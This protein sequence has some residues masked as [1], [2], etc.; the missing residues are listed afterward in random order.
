MPHDIAIVGISCRFPGADHP[1]AYWDLLANG[2]SAITEV[3]PWRWDPERFY[4]PD[5]AV[6]GKANTR[7]GGFLAAPGA[8]DPA[9]FN[10][11][12]EEA[13]HVD[14]Q[15]RLILELGWEA[16]EDAGIAPDTL[17]GS[18]TG[19]YIGIS[20]NDYER[21]I[22]RSYE[23]ITQFHGTGSYQSVAAARLSYFL[24]LC[25]PSMAVDT[26]CSSALSALHV[27]ASA[28]RQ[29][30]IPLALVGGVTLHLTPDETI[31]LT[32]GRM[33]SGDGRCKSFD[34]H[35]DGYVRGEGGGML[36]LKRLED[37]LRDRDRIHGVVKGSAVNHNGRSNG[38]SAPSGP[39]LKK[40][41][42]QALAGAGIDADEVTLLEAHGTGTR[43]GD[44]IEL[45]AIRDTYDGTV[46]DTLWLGCVK[47]NIGHL[48][49]ASGMASIVKVLLAMRHRQ[50]P[51]N[52]HFTGNS[53]LTGADGS[54]LRVPLSLTPWHSRRERPLAAI[55]AYGFGG[56]NG[57]VLLEAP[58]PVPRADP[59]PGAQLLCLSARD[60]AALRALLQAYQ[61]VLAHP[62][63]PL[64]DLCC[65]AATGRNHF[66][67]RIAFVARDTGDLA[68]QI[69]AA[70]QQ[71]QLGQRAVRAPQP[72]LWFGPWPDGAGALLAQA[73]PP[74]RRQLAALYDTLGLGD[75]DLTPAQR[76]F[77]A[78][79]ALAHWLAELGVATA[80]C[81][82]DGTGH[83]VAAHQAGRMTLAEAFASAGKAPPI[84]PPAP[85]PQPVLLLGATGPH[86]PT[87]PLHVFDPASAP[88]AALLQLLQALYTLGVRIDW[89]RWYDPQHHRQATLPT[90]PF[91]R[92]T[93]W[94]TLEQPGGEPVTPALPLAATGPAA[95][96]PLATPGPRAVAMAHW[97]ADYARTRLDS[98]LIDERRC[99][100]PHVVQA[101]G[102]AG[103]MGLLVPT[104]LQGSA[105][106]IRDC[107]HVFEQA[108]AVDIT[109]A[110]FLG[111]H[112]VLGTLPLLEGATPAW[113]ERMLPLLATGGTL[114]A[115]AITERGAGSNP[116]ALTSTARPAA[117][118]SLRLDGHKI[119]IGS[120]AWAGVIS[121]F[122]NE[123]DAAGRMLGISGFAVPGGAAGLRHGPE[124]LTMGV[125]G[126]VQNE[127]IFEG[128]RVDET[129]RLGMAGKGLTIAQHA[130]HLGRL[131]IA[132]MAVGA[133]KRCLQ[134]S[135][136]YAARR[137]VSTGLLG[138]NP[139]YLRFLAETVARIDAV[140]ALIQATA[141]LRDCG[142][143]LPDEL[144]AVA[145]I[146]GS[147]H[148]WQIVDGT[149]QFTG[150]RG[151]IET[152][153]IPQLFRDAR[154]LRIFEGPTEALLAYI[155]A[156]H[157]KGQ[158]RLSQFLDA[159]L[160]GVASR[161]LTAATQRLDALVERAG[162]AQRRAPLLAH[163][164]GGLLCEAALWA[165]AEGHCTSTTTD[166][167][168]ARFARA[169][170]DCSAQLAPQPAQD[171]G[172][173]RAHAARLA[174]QIGEVD[175]R[176]LPQD[177]LLQPDPTPAAVPPAAPVA[178]PIPSAP[179]TPA[180]RD[181]RSWLLAAIA[182][183]AGV[184]AAELDLERPFQE[185]GFDSIDA[186]EIAQTLEA[187]LGRELDPTMLWNY[188]TPGALLA[189]LFG[190][191]PA[192]QPIILPE[193]DPQALLDALRRELATS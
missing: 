47:T 20:H 13:V 172:A 32:K 175:Q 146:S 7:W 1:Q 10:M 167:C 49:T 123:C 147:E 30:E 72:A 65:T 39:A 6:P 110:S 3:P 192:E 80:D 31:G 149:M 120:G 182:A 158:H 21:I 62:T 29:H 5:P 54:R 23:R 137:A 122:V 37:A 78:Q 132:A 111:V 12:A 169:L 136:R 79:Q 155:G 44:Q 160:G 89:S 133:M 150:G 70:L 130:F 125:R 11:T 190:G 161:Q 77:L 69:D 179:G 156:A 163:A 107:L 139:V 93:L 26:A 76:A 143:T 87:A 173:L 126:M 188:P 40:V 119:W 151:Y 165:A 57:H 116:R 17:K 177:A 148:L 181:D 162:P 157:L 61:P 170:D 98:R 75:T 71:P 95:R 180:T 142:V 74:Y 67:W 105:L 99:I 135:E 60:P 183:K 145:K 159:H 50:I 34:Q 45:R 33:L 18:R 124:A 25:G 73:A 187:R 174:A 68:Q 121:V 154:L 58:P 92:Q 51:P 100:P 109:L 85:L 152:N 184:A 41:M 134:L 83:W 171:M 35:A 66:E 97:L 115:F 114:G 84:P 24:H 131:G 91:Q 8:C 176:D 22:Y 52:L 86:T 103:L 88:R 9:F 189:F 94:F 36:V 28:L 63:A 56:A 59:P 185:Y 81:A 127:L 64:A 2:Q 117:D 43:L 141:G 53:Q 14:P 129:Q 178:A 90:Y 140:S 166:W 96:A 153:Q 138:H 113:R 102:D 164:V 108:G 15:Q 104:A 186:V 193:T 112:N 16:L 4:D 27:A 144:Y 38:L 46:D 42:E 168:A 106:P 191:T 82:G 101:L 55:T 118:G 19:V 128:L 48:E